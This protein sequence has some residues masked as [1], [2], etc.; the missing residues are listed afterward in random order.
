VNDN[1]EY[2][3]RYFQ[4][5]IARL[6]ADTAFLHS[7]DCLYREINYAEVFP[8]SSCGLESPTAHSLVLS[9]NLAELVITRSMILAKSG[10][11]TLNFRRANFRLFKELLDEIPW[12]TVLRDKGM[13]QRWQ[14]FKDIFLRA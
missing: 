2:I 9:H 3:Q 8:N 7:S 1:L 6:K 13:K 14:L 11:R 5:L 10:V 12:E 4:M